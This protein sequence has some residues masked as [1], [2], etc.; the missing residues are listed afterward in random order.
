MWKALTQIISEIFQSLGLLFGSQDDSRDLKRQLRSAERFVNWGKEAKSVLDFHEA[1][2][3]LSSI[4]VNLAN[5]EDKLLIFHLKCTAN[6]GIIAS[7]EKEIEAF[8][9]KIQKQYDTDEYMEHVLNGIANKMKYLQEI[10]S[11]AEAGDT[12]K[13]KQIMKEKRPQEVRPEEIALDARKEY[14]IVEDNFITKRSIF[15]NKKNKIN[16]FKTSLATEI[17][18]NK[19]IIDQLIFD[20]ENLTDTL[21]EEQST[22][23]TQFTEETYKELQAIL[24]KLNTAGIPVLNERKAKT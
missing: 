1:L 18:E 19:K 9:K 2:K 22:K 8:E 17:I 5:V 7:K 3:I 23:R 10:I 13:L 15:E 20:A 16:V 14:E 12:I 6:I 21:T 4:R 11:T 24:T